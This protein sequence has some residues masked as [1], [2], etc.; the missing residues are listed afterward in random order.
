MYEQHPHADWY[1][2]ATDDSIW[3]IESL[4]RRL[5]GFQ[6]TEKHLLGSVGIW[7]GKAVLHKGNGEPHTAGGSG[8][9]MSNSLAHWWSTNQQGFLQECWH[10]DLSMGQYVRQALGLVALQ[11]DGVL[12]EPQF[13]EPFPAFNTI[14][15]CACPL[16]PPLYYNT[17]VYEKMKQGYA[18]LYPFTP[19]VW[20]EALAWHIKS[21]FWSS[22]FQIDKDLAAHRAKGPEFAEDTLLVYMETDSQVP[23]SYETLPSFK[24][25]PKK[26]PGAPVPPKPSLCVLR[27]FMR[28]LSYHHCD[29]TRDKRPAWWKVKGELEQSSEARLDEARAWAKASKLPANW[30]TLG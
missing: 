13:R 8:F 24:L 29:I 19:F 6:S 10:D 20:E 21:Q 12:Q 14:K 4:V 5:A 9:V 28:M 17:G 11:L 16:P 23:G 1:L 30:A 25:D 3:N 2:R 22:V 18:V 15:E 7:R 26:H 27:P